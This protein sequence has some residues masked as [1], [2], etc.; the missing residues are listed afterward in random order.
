MMTDMGHGGGHQEDCKGLDI[1]ALITCYVV[2]YNASS[3][4]N[5]TCP[6]CCKTLKQWQISGQPVIRRRGGIHLWHQV[7]VKY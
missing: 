6:G 4:I 1:G 5:D 7:T 3:Q 2:C